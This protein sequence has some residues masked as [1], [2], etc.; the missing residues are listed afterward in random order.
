MSNCTKKHQKNIKIKICQEI[1]TFFLNSFAYLFLNCYILFI[2]MNETI[3][4]DNA[5][6]SVTKFFEQEFENFPPLLMSHFLNRFNDMLDY[7]EEDLKIKY[8]NE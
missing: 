1:L 5:K 8:E 6:E 4:F 7:A 3:F 2:N